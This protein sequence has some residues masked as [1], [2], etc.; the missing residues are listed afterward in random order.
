MES[1][2]SLLGLNVLASEILGSGSS[3]DVGASAAQ[4]HGKS[5][6]SLPPFIT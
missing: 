1:L 5:F 3:K 4:S 2:Q 6:S